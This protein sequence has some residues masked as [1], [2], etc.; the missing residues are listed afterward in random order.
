M[1]A[2]RIG[3]LRWYAIAVLTTASPA[4]AQSIDRA[5][6]EKIVREYIMQNPEI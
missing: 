6:V 5:E 1:K 3:R 2:A 4:Y